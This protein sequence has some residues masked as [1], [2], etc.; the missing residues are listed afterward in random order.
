M[1]TFK[2]FIERPEFCDVPGGVKNPALSFID[3]IQMYYPEKKCCG[4]IHPTAIIAKNV[5]LGSKV[6]IAPHT[7]IENGVKIGD[8]VRIGAGSFIGSNSE[9]GNGSSISPNVSIYHDITIGN[10]CIIESGTVIGADGYG[11]VSDNNTHYKIP[12]IVNY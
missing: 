4:A 7:V 10:N 12:H 6:E 9:I 1:K 5:K 8:L 2:T 3:I 11:L